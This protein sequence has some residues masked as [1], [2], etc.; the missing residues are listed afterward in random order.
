MEYIAT[1]LQ[2]IKSYPTY[3][4]HAYTAN[5]KL[6]TDKV[7]GICVLETLKWLRLRLNQYATLPP[8]LTAPEPENY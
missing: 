6:S 8:E 5:E 1:K 2:P 7:F 4:L 3:Q